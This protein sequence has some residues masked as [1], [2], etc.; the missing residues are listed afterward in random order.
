MKT[1]TPP[2]PPQKKKT[3]SQKLK[4]KNWPK[5]TSWLEN[6]NPPPPPPMQIFSLAYLLQLF[7]Q[8]WYKRN[9]LLGGGGGVGI[10]FELTSVRPCCFVLYQWKAENC[11]LMNICHNMN[12]AMLFSLVYDIT[13][14]DSW[15]QN[16]SVHSCVFPTFEHQVLTNRTIN[17]VKNCCVQF[18]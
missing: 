11:W 14:A 2:P 13:K 12:I 7:C 15:A 9:A 4:M 18:F 16:G 5:D 3:N 17:Q 6:M 1:I 8:Y 10:K